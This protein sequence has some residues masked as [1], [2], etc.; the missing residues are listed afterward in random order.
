[1]RLNHAQGSE[2]ESRACHFLEQQGCTII[3]RNWHCRFGEIDIIAKNG[4][5]YLFIEVKYRKNQQFG[6][7]A[8][9]ITPAKLGKIS[10]SVEAYLQT[11]N[12]TSAACRI[13][14]ILI[15]GTA[16]P[17]WIQNLTG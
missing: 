14:A 15:E 2:A 10:R 7:S 6:G 4:H 3:A 12:L 11:Y 5:T 17:V 8:Y 1:M 16:T 9:S 13:D